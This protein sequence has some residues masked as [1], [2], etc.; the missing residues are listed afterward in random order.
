MDDDKTYKGKASLVGTMSNVAVLLYYHEHKTLLNII[1]YY[2]F[3]NICDACSS[4]PESSGLD[5]L[6]HSRLMYHLPLDSDGIP[7]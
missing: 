7:L 4:C 3:I 1:I 6:S 2:L 5:S